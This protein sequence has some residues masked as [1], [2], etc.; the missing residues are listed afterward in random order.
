VQAAFEAE[1]VGVLSRSSRDGWT[2]VAGVGPTVPDGPDA[3]DLAVPLS[4]RDVL[5][6]RGSGLGPDDLDVL[7]AFAGQVAV[8]MQQRALRADAA[9]AGDLEAANELRTALLAAVSHDLRTPLSS[10]KAAVSSL[11]QRDVDFTPAATRELL[12]TIDDGTDRLN[13]LVGNLLDMSRLQTGALQLA[14]R[15]VALEEVI[16]AALAGLSEVDRVDADVPET[17]PRVQADAALLER[18]VANVVENALKWSPT[19]TR[20]RVEA[21]VAEGRVDLRVVDRGAGI[22]I[23]QREHVFQP[24]QR[25]GDSSND[26]GVG[27][28]LAVARGFVEAMGGTITVDD[29][30]GGGVTIDIGLELAPS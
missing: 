11:L 28:G 20:V 30:P 12:D 5:V 16:P 19:D 2:V 7:Q 13:H 15:A 3:A 9:R 14:M 17:L 10:I 1:S 24:F 4:S 22:P 18:A 26:T 6:V 21:C 29:T 27:L 8:A 25:L 23:A